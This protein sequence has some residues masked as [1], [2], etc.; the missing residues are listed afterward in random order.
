[1]VIRVYLGHKFSFRRTHVITH[2]G[3][4]G[5]VLINSAAPYLL[6]HRC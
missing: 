5:V 6:A 2:G 3:P 1:M 4:L